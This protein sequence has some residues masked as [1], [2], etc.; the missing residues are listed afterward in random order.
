MSFTTGSGFTNG[1]SGL[2]QQLPQS[3]FSHSIIWSQRAAIFKTAEHPNAAKLYLNW[4]ISKEHQVDLG[5][6]SVR[7]DVPQQAGLKRTYRPFPRI[8]GSKLTLNSP[9]AL[10]DFSGQFDPPAFE[11]F[12]IDRNIVE[13]FR[14]QF[15]QLIGTAQGLSPLDDDI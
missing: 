9:A 12:M 1:S 13:R 2:F 6:W 4:F 5:G 10:S 11:Q 8:C 15:E 3:D 7:N 14:F